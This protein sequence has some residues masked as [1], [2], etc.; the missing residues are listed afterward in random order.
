MTRRD[1]IPFNSVLRVNHGAY[2]PKSNGE[3]HAAGCLM[4][5]HRLNITQKLGLMGASAILAMGLVAV[6]NGLSQRASHAAVERMATGKDIVADILPPPMYLIEARLVMSQTRDASLS[7]DEAERELK[8]L[9]KEF[10]DRVAYWQ[11]HPTHGLEGQLLGPHK[12]TA[13]A[14]LRD[15][16]AVLADDR[17]KGQVDAQSE[18]YRR[19]QESYKAHRAAV[20]KTVEAGLAFAAQSSAEHQAWGARGLWIN[21]GMFAGTLVLFS[22]L[23][24]WVG[25]SVTRPLQT[26]LSFIRSVTAGRIGAQ[27]PVQGRDEVSEL[28]RGLNEMSCSLAQIV[29]N[30]R[31]SCE[32]V[33]AGSE[34]IAQ[35]NGELCERTIQ[36]AGQLQETTQSAA[37]I[38]QHLGATTGYAQEACKLSG[39]V[40]AVASRGCDALQTV[41]QTMASIA[42]TSRRVG[43]ITSAIDGIAFQTNIL[44]LNA[45]VEAA[46]A[47]EHGKGFAVVASEVRHLAQRAAEAAR[48][49]KSSIASSLERVEHG[50]QQV[51]QASATMQELEGSIHK[52]TALVNDI[53]SAMSNQT[54]EL[55]HITQTIAQLDSVTQLNAAMVEECTAAA[56]A[57]RLQAEGLTTQVSGFQTV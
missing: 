38:S 51:Q 21:M 44:A 23:V 2:V 1:H 57:L 41:T 29:G 42:D 34:Q 48:E 26:A 18:A 37:R 14:F 55:G 22:A 45:A 33:A 17:K 56:Q 47:G 54:G 31:S 6:S 9:Q 19:M 15:A 52:V 12:A 16:V 40:S 27:A 39:H 36:Q 24:V 28:L 13:E 7:I 8:R 20:D 35:A 5:L 30:V 32:D 46:R 50:S 4:S 11:T 3:L 43:D 10:D 49:I 53:S 25:R